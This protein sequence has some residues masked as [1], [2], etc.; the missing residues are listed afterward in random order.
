MKN[1]IK[2]CMQIVL[3]IIVLHLF[4]LY[5]LLSQATDVISGVSIPLN[6]TTSAA[7]PDL[8]GV[9]QRDTLIPF[10]ILDGTGSVLVSGNVQDKVVKSTNLSN[11]IFSPRLRDITGVPG[12][13]ITSLTIEGYANTTTDIEYRT[14]GLG[15]T[16]PNTVNRSAGTGDS[17][18]F[19]FDP[20]IINPPNESRFLSILTNS[21]QFF[22]TGKITVFAQ[23]QNNNIFSTVLNKTAS[24]TAPPNLPPIAVNDTVVTAFNTTTP[25][26]NV[27]VN[28]SDPDGDSISITN[29]TNP[30]NGTVTQTGTDFVYTPNTGFSGNDSFSYTIT[31]AAGNNS[32]ADVNISVDPA[33]N[34]PPTIVPHNVPI[35]GPLGIIITIFALFIFGRR[36]K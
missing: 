15:N 6:G 21:S 5:P 16:G 18:F 2:K 36:S 25:A 4:F 27:L 12:S 29:N 10:Q 9:V 17:L 22:L 7:N 13:K 24:P 31:D 34:Q 23:D 26:I 28:D 30:S 32:T 19:T 14:D 3:Q 35:F 11:L 8:G 20:S 33:V 1:H